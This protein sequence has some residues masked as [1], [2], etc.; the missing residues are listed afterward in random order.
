MR[1][2]LALAA[3]LPPGTPRW[4]QTTELLASIVDELERAVYAIQAVHADA[5]HR[6][7]IPKPVRVPRPVS[8]E[9]EQG[10]RLRGEP[11]IKPTRVFESA[12]EFDAWRASR[13]RPASPGC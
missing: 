8:Q 6:S 10:S 7:R 11:W 2:L 3:G 13:L 12:A 1:E 5:R 4:D 9:Q